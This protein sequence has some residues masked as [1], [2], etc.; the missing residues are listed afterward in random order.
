[1]KIPLNLTIQQLK[2]I[3]KEAESKME[4]NHY[5]DD[6]LTFH[7]EP[8]KIVITQSVQEEPSGIISSATIFDKTINTTHSN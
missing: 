6:I 7:V 1:M 2:R 8:T 5:A 3:V 4:E